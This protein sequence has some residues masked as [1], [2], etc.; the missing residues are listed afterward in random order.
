[1]FMLL[2][3]NTG[4]G[5]NSVV[6]MIE[7]QVQHVLSCL[8]RLANEKADVVEVRP[9]AQRRFNDGIRRRLGKA[10]WNEGGCKSWYLDDKGRNTTL[11]PD[12]SFRFVRSL[13]RFDPSEY[14]LEPAP[15]REKVAA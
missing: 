12:F 6:F 14:V 9:K 2:G 8:D 7:S 13:K 11:W 15:V 10:V 3:P 1:M 4:L 5:H